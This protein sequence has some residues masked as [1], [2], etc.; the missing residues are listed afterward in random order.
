MT[1]RSS[2]LAAV[3]F[4]FAATAAAQIPF[5]LLVSQSNSAI[6]VQNG[7]SLTFVSAVGQSQTAQLTATYTGTGQ[8]VISQTPNVF[9]SSA[10]T[11]TLANKLPVTLSPGGSISI[12]INFTPTSATLSSSQLNLPYVETV[13]TTTGTTTSTTS[14]ANVITLGLQG[15]PPRLP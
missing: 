1:S 9:G 8:V 5:Q 7:A 3:L 2:G 10:F 13:S 11:A 12:T 15:P 4:A 14:T 6:N